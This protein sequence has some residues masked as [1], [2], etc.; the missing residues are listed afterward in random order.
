MF[1]LTTLYVEGEMM[2]KNRS[3]RMST[4]LLGGLVLFAL[5]ACSNTNKSSDSSQ[6]QVKSSSQSVQKSTSQMSSSMETSTSA[7]NTT[8]SS[9]ETTS[10][11]KENMDITAIANGD[12]TTIKG[13]WKND[14][15]DQLVF[16][17]NGLASSTYTFYGVSL[18]DYGTAAG[19]VYG[20]DTGGFLLELVPKG[21]QLA[22]KE[23][24]KDNS[25]TSRDRIWTGVGQNS[26]EQQGSFYYRVD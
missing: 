1:I 2:K 13:T 16:D 5:T 24:F 4:F 14:S 12:Y 19:G 17:E 25:D 26:F 22:E 9:S 10:E 8:S 3:H 18:T 20:G 23:S 15:G 7:Q 11:K 6:T 21:L